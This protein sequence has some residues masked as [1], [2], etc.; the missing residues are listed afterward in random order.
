MNMKK[1]LLAGLISA[2]LVS[3]LIPIAMAATEEGI[4]ITFDPSGTI[5]IDVGPNSY[6]FGAADANSWTNSTG[7]TFTLYNN[8]TTSMDTQIKTNATTDSSSMTLDP[9]GVSIAADN[10]SLYTTG[11]DTDAYITTS[12]SAEFDA[13]LASSGSTGFDLDIRLAD[14]SQDWSQQTTTIYFQG[15]IAN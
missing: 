15:S 12:Y 4:T 9:D 1:I 14:I 6:A 10:Y 7:S 2:M 11:L 3:A 5:D 8:G 13:A